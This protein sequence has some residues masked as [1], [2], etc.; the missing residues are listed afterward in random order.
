MGLFPA[1]PSIRLGGWFR[2][3][4]LC[5]PGSHQPGFNSPRRAP[6]PLVASSRSRSLWHSPSA[7]PSAPPRKTPSFVFSPDSRVPCPLSRVPTPVSA[8]FNNRP[9]CPEWRYLIIPCFWR[10]PRRALIRPLA[11][12]SP[13]PPPSRP[14]PVCIASTATYCCH[15][16]AREIIIVGE[17]FS[18]FLV[19][20]VELYFLS[21]Q[22]QLITHFYQ[23]YY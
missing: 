8:F 20:S 5:G 6:R 3:G 10:V 22:E 1:S 2:Q 18:V 17:E 12:P 11:P 13:S 19:F 14:S 7:T 15:V 23:S 9:P 4:A 21:Y 16:C